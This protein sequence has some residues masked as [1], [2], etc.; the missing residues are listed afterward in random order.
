MPCYHPI[1]A[2]K[3]ADGSV[4]FSERSYFNIVQNLSLPC[5]QCIGC[6]LERSR[7]W[8][9]RC[10]HEAQLHEES[11]F[12]TL[13]YNPENLPYDDSLNHDHFQRFLKRLRKSIAPQRIRFYMAGEYGTKRGRPHYH[14]AIFGWSPKD[15][16]NP[17]K[18]PAG[19]LI[20]TSEELGNAWRIR[21]TNTGQYESLGFSSVGELTFESAAYIARYIVSKQTGKHNKYHNAYTDLTTGE[22]VKRKP[23]YNRMSLRPMSGIKGEPGGIASE[24]FKKYKTDVYPHDY[25][26]VRGQKMKPPKYY[27]KLLKKIDPEEF[28][29]IIYNR[30]KTAK[31]NYLDN[32]PERLLVKEQVQQARLDKLKR[33]LT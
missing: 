13:T 33:N 3:T 32:T 11:C 22:I 25:V 23:E 14:A 5:G 10:M 4:V 27:D 28:E 9:M 12:I 16:K 19:S 7:Q 31:L 6:R 20:Y 24:W 30:E 2:Y 1:S 8:A 18:T 26:I 17:K 29:D 15:K 21:N